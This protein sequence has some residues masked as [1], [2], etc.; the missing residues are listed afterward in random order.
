MTGFSVR[1]ADL[2]DVP[3][4]L[5]LAERAWNATYET[6]LSQRTIDRAMA[7]WYDFEGTREELERD[8]I[9]WFVATDCNELLG[10]VAGGPSQSGEEIAHLGAIYVNP[11]HWNQGIGTAL[12][13]EFEDW[14]LDHGFTHLTFHVL[15]EN[16]IGVSFYQKHGYDII[17]EEDMELF[18]DGVAQYDFLGPIE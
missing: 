3:D 16:D 10:Y 18:Y 8:D 1:Q 6:I 13:H 12:L 9:G 15:V 2:D 11:A 4:I 17:E 7:E 5:D 14:C